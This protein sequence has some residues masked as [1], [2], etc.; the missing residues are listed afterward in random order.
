M[1]TR[2]MLEPLFAEVTRSGFGA[3]FLKGLSDDVVFVASGTSPVSGRYAGKQ[4]YVDKVLKPLG[5]KLE[6]MP[7]PRVERMI[8]DGEWASVLFRT[9]GVR[10]KN[11]A[12]FSMQY[13]WIIHVVDNLIVEIT[14]FYDQKKMIDIF[15]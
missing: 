8:V 7:I 12:D 13:C 3:N 6:T 5:E 1:T 2:G 4:V 10:G 14:G 15:A 9:E 11:G